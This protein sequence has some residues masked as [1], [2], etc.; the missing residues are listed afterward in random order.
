MRKATLIGLFALLNLFSN[1]TVAQEVA[2]TER[3]DSVVLFSNGTWDYY[4][5]YYSGTE[6]VEEIRMNEKEFTKPKSSAKKING[7]NNAYEVWY[8]DKVWKRIP[9][10]DINPDA[11]LALQLINGDVYAM[12]IYE[13]IEMPFENLA[14]IA[15][16]NAL[17]AAADIKLVDKEYR[18]V[19]NDTLICMRMDGTAQGMKIAYYSYYFSNEKGSI[20]FH[21][22]TG[23]NLIDKYKNEIDDLLNG[24]ITD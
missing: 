22:F 18:V 16:D 19:N 3:G 8:N 10:G 17:N 1:Y 9:V 5:N 7:M 13:E 12:V 6:E 11:D 4:D 2:I 23:Q 15:L 21:T 24:L 20:Q 14:Q